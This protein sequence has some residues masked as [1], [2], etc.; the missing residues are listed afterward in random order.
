M[1]L[2]REKMI[3][4]SFHAN[5]CMYECRVS[6]ARWR[7]HVLV[8]GVAPLLLLFSEKK[9][10]RNHVSLDVKSY[11]NVEIH[12]VDDTIKHRVVSKS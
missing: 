12:L 4:I 8:D 1:A 11:E 9:Y 6:N 5:E 2:G 10:P 7:L 3:V